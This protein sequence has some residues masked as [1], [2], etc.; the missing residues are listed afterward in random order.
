[1]AITKVFDQ[2]LEPV[3]RTLGHRPEDLG[4]G[5]GTATIT[6][7]IEMVEDAVAKG[8]WKAFLYGV[9]GASTLYLSGQA[10]DPRTKLEGAIIGS[11]LIA[12]L[13]E[14]LA[15]NKEEAERTFS[16]FMEAVARGDIEGALDTMVKT[17]AIEGL[18]AMAAGQTASPSPKVE[19]VESPKVEV[20]E[21]KTEPSES[22]PAPEV[23]VEEEK[24]QA[25][26]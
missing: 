4:V 6:K 7:I 25:I 1:M 24:P 16:A 10:R 22:A 14:E 21:V 3:A 13:I 18:V 19:V 17:D 5:A 2:V 15:K 26:V 9:G 12:D 11:N 20:V 23:K 8:W